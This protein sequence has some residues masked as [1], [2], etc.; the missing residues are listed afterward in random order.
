M[1][2]RTVGAT[3]ILESKTWNA[4]GVGDCNA[5]ASQLNWSRQYRLIFA[6][7]CENGPKS[8]LFRP[9]WRSSRAITA[10]SQLKDIVNHSERWKSSFKCLIPQ[11]LTFSSHCQSCLSFFWAF[12]LVL[13][14]GVCFFLGHAC[15]SRLTFLVSCFMLWLILQ[16]SYNSMT[17]C[18]HWMTCNSVSWCSS[19]LR[20]RRRLITCCTSQH[21]H[22][23][24]LWV[25]SA[26]D[27]LP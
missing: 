22:Q 18:R 2:P 7:A 1:A 3:K 11:P 26:A 19:M 8:V 16:H 12:T 5:Q 25:T 23:K 24:C 10:K 13:C 21:P 27:K 6:Q 4:L 9:T 15:L 20:S 14:L 17:C